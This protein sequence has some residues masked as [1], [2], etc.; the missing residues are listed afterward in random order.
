MH[1]YHGSKDIIKNPQYAFGKPYND[2]GQGFYCTEDID[3]AR[4]W[5]VDLNRDG[6]VNIYD[7]NETGLNIIDLTSKEYCVLHWITILLQNRRFAL[8]TPL[9]REAYSYLTKN[10]SINLEN[11]D[12]I[13]GYRAD[14]SYF[15]YAQDFVNGEISVSKLSEAMHLGDL[16]C[17]LMIKSETAFNRLTYVGCEGVS[18]SEWY[19][20]KMTRDRLARR[21]YLNTNR[22]EYVR[23]ELYMVRI[24]DEEVRPDDPRL[25]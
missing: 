19:S 7:F 13:F 11:A 15:S 2:Y 3:L 5:S 4:E 20:K 16:G 23:G 14:D 18:A 25:R 22:S 6:F 24:I 8:E 10:F 9:A 17:Q 1:L 21:A 12:A